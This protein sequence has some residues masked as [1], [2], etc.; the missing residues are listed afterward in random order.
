M[1]EANKHHKSYG[2]K[3]KQIFRTKIRT[4]GFSF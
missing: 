3:E 1:G 2:F 4:Y